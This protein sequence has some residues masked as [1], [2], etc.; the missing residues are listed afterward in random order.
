MDGNY[1]VS[2]IVGVVKLH[3][4]LEK[5]SAEATMAEIFMK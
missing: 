3:M 1:V 5:S 2:R 4:I